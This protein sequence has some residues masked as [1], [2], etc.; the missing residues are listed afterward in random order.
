MLTTREFVQA[1]AARKMLV[2]RYPKWRLI[3]T[4]FFTAII[5]ESSTILQVGKADGVLVKGFSFTEELPL[6]MIIEIDPLAFHPVKVS[7][8]SRLCT[9]LSRLKNSFQ[10]TREED[11]M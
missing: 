1:K 6:T 11:L 10:N 8:L 3:S 5:P 2:K 7:D 9:Q 4:T